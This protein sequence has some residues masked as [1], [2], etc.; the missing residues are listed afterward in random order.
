MFIA[1]LVIVA[2]GFGKSVLG[3]SLRLGLW[4]GGFLVEALSHLYMPLY[5]RI[6]KK[7]L[8]D[9]LPVN[10]GVQ[11]N[12][13]LQTITAIIL[14]EG[15]NGIASILAKILI[16]PEAA[17]RA[18][19]TT[20]IS[21]TCTIWFIAYIYFGGPKGETGPAF[22]SARGFQR[23][24]LHFPLL[25]SIVLLLIGMKHQCFVTCFLTVWLKSVEMFNAEIDALLSVAN[26]TEWKYD[27]NMSRYLSKCGIVWEEEFQNLISTMNNTTTDRQPIGLELGVAVWAQR[28]SLT[29]VVN[30]FKAFSSSDPE[31]LLS[32][33]QPDI[34]EYY[35]NLEQVIHDINIL[36]TK[37]HEAK[38]YQ[39]LRGLLDG[40]VLSTR[41]ITG[42]AGMLLI[43]LGL[44]DFVH[45]RPRGLVLCLLLLLNLGDSQEFLIPENGRNHQL[46]VFRWL[47][48]YGLRD[49]K[50]GQ[51]ILRHSF[52]RSWVSPIIAIAYGVQ[53]MIEIVLARFVKRATDR[54][55]EKELI[56]KREET[57]HEWGES[58]NILYVV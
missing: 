43:S 42:F 33:I 16:A 27:E 10:P 45:S 54:A 31:A 39:I 17:G 2:N 18:V 35:Q 29:I 48:A 28:S 21:A 40:P 3:A 5:W 22:T 9:P 52:I 12:E 30:L 4:A 56:R 51:D 55:Q 47:E 36:P 15:I 41:W 38:Y 11:L 13:R 8:D 50:F 23:L 32:N 26:I 34:T 37:P 46:G 1:A 19:A 49:F 6:Y 44:I 7:S 58:R 53:F 57:Q 20:I 24:M 25:T 14:G